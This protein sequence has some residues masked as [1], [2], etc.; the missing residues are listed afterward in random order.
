M[1][2]N[3]NNKLTKE[4]LEEL[5]SYDG[6]SMREIAGETG[7]TRGQIEHLMEKYDIPRR[8]ASQAQRIRAQ[9]VKRDKIEEAKVILEDTMRQLHTK[10]RTIKPVHRSN[11]LV[12]LTNNKNNDCVLTLVLSDLHIGDA[13]HLPDTYWSTIKNAL[14]IIKSIKKNY[15][16]RSFKLVLNGDM[17]SGREVY[18]LQELRNILQRGHWQVFMCEYVIKK[19]IEDLEKILNKKINKVYLVRGTHEGLASNFILYLKRML[20]N[21][22]YYL[23]HGGI[24]NIADPIGEYN[25]FFTHGRSYSEYCPVPPRLIRDCLELINTYKSNGIYIERVCSSHT[26]WLCSSIIYGDIYWDVTGGFQKWEYTV[27]QRPCGAI[28]YF[29]ANNELSVIPVRPDSKIE[30]EERS[31]VGLEYKNLVYYGKYLL[32]HLKEIELR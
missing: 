27:S 21:K 18:K 11:I 17:V 6:L 20:G 2:K 31:E 32:S 1:K 13:N 23:S 3:N 22:A 14:E 12:P 16:V 8:T 24:V 9:R 19:T 28:L 10:K 30:K 7:K 5:Y 26:H 25:V 29:F 4:D 15:K